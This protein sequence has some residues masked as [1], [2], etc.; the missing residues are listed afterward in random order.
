MSIIKEAE[1]RDFTAGGNFS[2][3]VKKNLAVWQLGDIWIR[4][5]QLK[6]IEGDYE[7]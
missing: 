4:V 1:S 2:S 7:S 5:N 3:Q 6:S